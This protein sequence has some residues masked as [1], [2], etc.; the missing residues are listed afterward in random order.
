MID[1]QRLSLEDYERI[2][3]CFTESGKEGCEYSF[4]NLYLWGKQ[5]GAWINDYFVVFSHYM[6]HSV[7]LFPAGTGDIAPVLKE[8]E[9][10]AKERGIPFRMTALIKQDCEQVE[11][12][13]PGRF[14]FVPDRAGCD[15][16]YEIDHLADLKGKA[17][18]QKRNHINRFLEAA[19]DW[20][21]EE[22]CNK[23]IPLCR[24]LLDRWYTQHLAL[25]P[26]MDY[27]LERRAVDRALR[28]YDKLQLEGLILYA[29]DSAVAMTIGSPLSETVFD[30]HFEKALGEIQGDY[31]MINRT[32]ARFLREK[33]PKLQYL[34][35]EDDMGLPGLRKA[36]LSYHPDKMVEQYR[37]FMKEDLYVP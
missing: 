2:Y 6:G 28:D 13:F 18:Q 8:M 36:K 12:V 22:I 24:A 27:H 9:L 25:D 4:V 19:P 26:K 32:F 21:I 1:F 20:R 33:Y 31:A 10:D 5:V 16:L 14:Q 29:G 11:S 3:R 23:N 15:Y 35:R 17:Y 30:I 34:N 37:C 7:Y